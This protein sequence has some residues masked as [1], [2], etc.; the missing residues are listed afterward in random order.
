MLDLFS[1]QTE[2]YNKK[3]KRFINIQREMSY[4]ACGVMLIWPVK[5]ALQHGEVNKLGKARKSI[6]WQLRHETKKDHDEAFFIANN[7]RGV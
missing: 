2:W 3:T 1:I 4:H 7:L 5:I 6:Y